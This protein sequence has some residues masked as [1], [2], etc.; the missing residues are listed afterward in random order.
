MPNTK[1]T[2]CLTDG[3]FLLKNGEG[4][5]RT[6]IERSKGKAASFA[7]HSG[8][9][10]SWIWLFSILYIR[11]EKCYNLRQNNRRE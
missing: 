8:L 7:L 3:V 6:G 11:P 9:Y 4:L 2:V 10:F 1:N 5:K